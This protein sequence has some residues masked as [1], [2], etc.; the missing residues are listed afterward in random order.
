MEPEEPI[1]DLVG[2]FL[3]ENIR[4]LDR[5]GISKKVED[6]KTPPGFVTAEQIERRTP[7][8]SIHLHAS[9]FHR[10]RR[11]RTV[12][13][14]WRGEFLPNMSVEIIGPVFRPDRLGR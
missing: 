11:R 2:V 14:R 4:G 13:G 5:P 10:Y 9:R 12:V 7:A 3:P 1:P 8:L 6:D